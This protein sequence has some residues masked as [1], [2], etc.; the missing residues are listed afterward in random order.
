M[1]KISERFKNAATYAASIEKWVNNNLS[2][3]PLEY[4]FASDF[5]LADYMFGEK[6]VRDIYELVKKGWL[7][8]YKVW[9]E[10][11]IAINMLS[12]A[13]DQLRKQGYEGREPFINLYNELYHQSVNDFYEKYENDEEKCYYFFQMTD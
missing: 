5:A 13:Q 6:G 8:N 9:T 3:E 2:G 7:D 4:T 11:V 12:W 1:K 10:V